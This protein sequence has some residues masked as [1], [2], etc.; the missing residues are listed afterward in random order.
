MTNVHEQVNVFN[1]VVINIFSNFVPDKIDDRDPIWMNVLLKPKLN[2]KI[3]HSSLD[4][5]T[6]FIRTNN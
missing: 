4:L 6:R 3:K 2:K 1:N 5:I